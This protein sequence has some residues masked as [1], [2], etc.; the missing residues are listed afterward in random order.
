MKKQIVI[1][2]LIFCL[3]LAAGVLAEEMA[4]PVG[5]WYCE[6]NDGDAAVFLRE[7]GTG[8][9]LTRASMDAEPSTETFTWSQNGSTVILEQGTKIRPCAYDGETLT[10]MENGL[11]LV[12][13]PADLDTESAV[14]PIFQIA[15]ESAI[16]KPEPEPL[17]PA[18]FAGKWILPISEE[19]CVLTLATNEN[20]S[21]TIGSSRY[22]GYTWS[23]DG[24]EI[25]LARG[26]ETLIFTPDDGTLILDLSGAKLR[27]GR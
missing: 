9:A 13:E 14:M 21:F 3:I 6:I 1:F 11:V 20:A 12:Y 26:E 23:I 22:D 25:R 2:E 15:E 16:Q 8:A 18:E 5:L 24:Q 27:F 17:N 7:D 10:F 4:S 19:E